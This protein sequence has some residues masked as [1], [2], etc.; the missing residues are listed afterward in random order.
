MKIADLL[1]R[2]HRSPVIRLAGHLADDP[3][4]VNE[5][6]ASYLVFR[7]VETE[8]MEFRLK[9]FPTTPKRHRG[10]RVEIIFQPDGGPAV[11]VDSMFAAPD[12]QGL[13]RR[14]REYLASVLRQQP[15]H[16]P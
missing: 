7:L 9:L 11:M 16:G 5:R 1:H 10:D 8:D 4:T 12:A 15:K 6:G 2:V 3:Q 13:R 14:H